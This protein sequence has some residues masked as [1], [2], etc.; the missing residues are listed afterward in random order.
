MLKQNESA[1]KNYKSFLEFTRD[2]ATEEQCLSYLC[3]LKWGAGFSCRR[4]KHTVAI[5][6]HKW[7]HRRC[8][9]CN[10]NES[11]TAH[12]LFHKLKFSVVKAFW[13]TYQ[14]S[15]MKKG[16]S[17]LE[18]SRQFDIHQ[19]TAWFFKRKVQQAM[20]SV[21]TPI[22]GGL[23]EVDET[24]IGGVEAGKPGRSHGKK[25][26]VQVALEIAYDRYDEPFVKRGLAQVIENY[27]AEE[28]GSAIEKM[29]SQHAVVC[30]D[31]WSA[32]PNAVGKREHIT[33]RSSKGSNFQQLHWH[34][35]NLKNW[36]RGIHHKISAD[37][38]QRYLDEYYF[39]FN[40]R[41]YSGSNPEIMIKAML[42]HAW[43]PYKKAIAA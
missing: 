33:F 22:L 26:I 32:Y 10:Y 36:I 28:L 11:S 43:M 4:C 41:N 21:D 27:S 14:L 2:F 12:T 30:T 39:R 42:N 37:H 1:M 7:H 29:V 16:M 38:L 3:Q 31:E 25:K 35:F 6:G 19:E 20:Q 34:I 5:K 17:T 13:I 15:T 23:V 24:V 8:Q 9:K 40:R 18:I